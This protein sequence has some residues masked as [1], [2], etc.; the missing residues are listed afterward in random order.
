[1]VYRFYNLY[2]ITYFSMVVTDRACSMVF[3]GSSFDIDGYH[4]T[5]SNFIKELLLLFLIALD[6]SITD[7]VLC[8]WFI[9]FFFF[10]FIFNKFKIVQVNKP[11]FKIIMEIYFV[12]LNSDKYFPLVE[13]FYSIVNFK[14]RCDDFCFFVDVIK[15]R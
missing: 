14:L 11:T 5:I 12:I 15:L 4:S 3:D 2:L 6:H 1:M 7:L 13:L 8:H 9:F 10:N